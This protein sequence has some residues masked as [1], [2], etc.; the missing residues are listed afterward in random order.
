MD[1][2]TDPIP[3]TRAAA[4]VRGALKH[5]VRMHLAG[6]TSEWGIVESRRARYHYGIRIAEPFLSGVHP[7]SKLVFD[8]FLG[9]PMCMD[10]MKWLIHKVRELLLTSR[11]N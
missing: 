3:F 10:R 8:P 2:I 1:G 9:I 5:G 7:E 4:I 11:S 6:A